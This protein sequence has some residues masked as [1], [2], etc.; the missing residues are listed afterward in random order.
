MSL[1][2]MQEIFI[3]LEEE[4]EVPYYRL[5][6]WGR[7]AR[8]ALAKLKNMGLIEK[9]Q[10]NNEIFYTITIEGENYFDD[11]LKTLKTRMTWDKKWRLVMFE[12]PETNRALR[13]KLRRNLSNLGLGIL[14]AGVWISPQPIDREIKEIDEKLKLGSQMK[15]FVVA[16][17]PDLNHEII[18]KSWNSALINDELEKFI[19]E[20]QGTLK[21]MIKGKGDSDK[22]SAKKL[23]FTYALILKKGP[24]LPIEFI[25]QN[26]IRITAQ[27]IYTKLR[28]FVV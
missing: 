6:R 10:K 25:E 14:Q 9:I 24:I 15:Y 2:P 5:E 1:S 4:K 8:G 28:P 23:I 22:F 17:N 20:A 16:A 13:D 3:F 27:E 12:I 19:K 26:E 7:P 11:I 21:S 18:S